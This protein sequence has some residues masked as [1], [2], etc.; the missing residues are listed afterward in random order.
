MAKKNRKNII[1]P[2]SLIN[3]ENLFKYDEDR[4]Q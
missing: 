2:I 4:W 1:I 3:K